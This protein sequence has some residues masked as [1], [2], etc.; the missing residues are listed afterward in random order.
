MGLFFKSKSNNYFKRIEA[1]NKKIEAE[2]NRLKL[3]KEKEEEKLR[4]IREKEEAKLKIIREKE[5]VKRQKSEHIYREKT[6]DYNKFIIKDSKKYIV[7]SRPNYDFRYL[8][9][10][11]QT[12]NLKSCEFFKVKLETVRKISVLCPNLN[13]NQSLTVNI[14]IKAVSVIPT[15]EKLNR[16]DI[17]WAILG[18]S[19]NESQITIWLKEKRKEKEIEQERK[20][21]KKE[22][23]RRKKEGYIKTQDDLDGD[24]DDTYYYS[25]LMYPDDD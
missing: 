1:E 7:I 17:H 19:S 23:E 18:P 21:R 4:I 2:N 24:C 11:K 3:I 14:D 6:P 5:E 16:F 13:N 22:I 9:R 15:N 25:C 10:Y 12:S 20:L 8:D